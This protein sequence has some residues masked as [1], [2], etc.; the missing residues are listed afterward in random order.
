MKVGAVRE[1]RGVSSCSQSQKLKEVPV[2]ACMSSG[3]NKSLTAL[4]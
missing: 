2:K 3:Y 4:A 1:I